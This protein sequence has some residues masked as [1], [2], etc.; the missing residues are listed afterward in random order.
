MPS[1]GVSEDSNSMYSHT[2]NKLKKKKKTDVS[3]SFINSVVNCLH[4]QCRRIHVVWAE[5]GSFVARDLAALGNRT[6]RSPPYTRLLL[7]SS[8]LGRH[9]GSEFNSS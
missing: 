1:S 5:N 7:F 6:W 9:S 4:S 3:V 8:A 2:L